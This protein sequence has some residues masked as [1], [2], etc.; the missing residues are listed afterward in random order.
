MRILCRDIPTRGSHYKD[1]PFSAKSIIRPKKARAAFSLN[2]TI[3]VKAN[4]D[5]CAIHIAERPFLSLQGHVP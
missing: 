2:L 1:N 3:V 5:L 4:V